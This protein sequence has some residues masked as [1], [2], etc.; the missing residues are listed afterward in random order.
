[1]IVHACFKHPWLLRAAALALV[2]PGCARGCQSPPEPE[3]S[4]PIAPLPDVAIA[5][6]HPALAV[7]TALGLRLPERH[8]AAILP[9]WDTFPWR[10][11][12][13]FRSDQHLT[14]RIGAQGVAILERS[15]DANAAH[16]D[17][18]ITELLRWALDQWQKRSGIAANRLILAIDTNA[19]REL[20]ARVRNVALQAS[21]WRVVGL[22]RDDEYLVELLLS[23]PP[24][25]RPSGQP[26]PVAP[27]ASP[28]T[29]SGR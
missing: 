19:E 3:S 27:M 20:I 9:G 25:R 7:E 6:R 10:R 24:D 12:T 13:E 14:V 28:A 21:L 8:N 26:M 5:P 2:G 17:A 4:P 23:P 29:G 16:S 11:L 18:R 1:M 22:S 15:L